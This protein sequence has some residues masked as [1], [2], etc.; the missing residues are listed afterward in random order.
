MKRTTKP[1]TKSAAVVLYIRVSTEEQARGGVS[2]DAQEATLRAYCTMRGLEVAELVVDAGV[3]AGAPLST[4]AGGARVLD[5]A[6]RGHVAGVVATKLD[7][8]FRDCGDCLAVTREWDG[9]QIAL[10]L[11]DLG[12]Q[13]IDTS[14]AMGRF[15]LTVMAGAAELERGMVAERTVAAM[16]HVKAQGRRVGAVPYGSSLAPDG[17]TLVDDEVE[18]AV[19]REARELRAAGLSLRGVAA[20]LARRGFCARGG[21]AFQ[22]MQVQRLVEA[23]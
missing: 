15:F 10:H 21:S 4:R 12:G 17:R 18:Q 16:A 14:S 23:A 11:V 8:L 6:R 22:P 7:R 1:V 3:S 20:E 13:S 19:I 2:L 9:A 5:L